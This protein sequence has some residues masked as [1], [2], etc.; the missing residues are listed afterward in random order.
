MTMNIASAADDV[1]HCET[2]TT[3]RTKE[4]DSNSKCLKTDQ[5]WFVSFFPDYIR[6]LLRRALFSW[7][8]WIFYWT[9]LRSHFQNRHKSFVYSFVLQQISTPYHLTITKKWK[10]KTT[11]IALAVDI[12]LSSLNQ[13]HS[14][15]WFEW[16]IGCKFHLELHFRFCIGWSKIHL[17]PSNFH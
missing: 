5:R 15:R 12:D 17:I 6:I 1:E 10:K 7:N 14:R 3:V 9:G 8:S 2:M 13:S 16:C 4:K 11:Q